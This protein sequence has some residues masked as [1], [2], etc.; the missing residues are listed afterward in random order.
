MQTLR[1]P[2]LIVGA[3]TGGLAAA[4]AC[5]RNGVRCIL[6]E[7]T[8]WV[9]GQLTTQAVPPDENPWIEGSGPN[10][11]AGFVGATAAYAQLRHEVREW[12]RTH[13]PLRPKV[14][15][16]PNLNPGAGWVSRLCAEPR[17]IE[18]VLRN[19]ITRSSFACNIDL[20]TGL[21][22]FRAEH[23]DDRIS[24][25]I[26]RDARTNE[27]IAIE[28]NLVL[29]A[30][31]LGDVLDLGS[32]ESLIGAE[33]QAV[34]GELHARTDLRQ[35]QSHDERDQQAFSW[36][37]AMEH[38]P[39]EDH[40]ID[41]PSGYDRWRTYVPEMAPPW[42]GPLMS[43]TVPSHDALKGRTLPMVPWPDE[44]EE[45]LLELW[46][47]R[48]IVNRAAYLETHAAEYP[49]VC[50]VNWVQ[51]D[52]WQHILLGVSDPQR[53]NAY[54]AAREQSR[55]LLYWMQTEAPRH[56]GGTGYP[57]L[58]LRGDELGTHDGFAKAAYIREPRRLLARTMLTEAHVGTEQRKRDGRPNQNATPWGAGEPFPDSIAIGHYPIDLH[59]TAAGRNNVYVP[60]CPFRIP[61]SSLVPVRVRNLIAAGKA[62]GVSHVANGCT[63]LHPVEWA[64]GEAAGLL[65]AWC[66]THGTEPFAV[67]EN[68]EAVA[69]LRSEAVGQGMPVSWPWES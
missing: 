52:H 1:T 54:E 42:T 11:P 39:E 59:P 62:L 19:T 31:D 44:P 55:C 45:G 60:A 13:R 63:R 29:D 57:G 5:A 69:R 15:A 18:Q 34:F 38:R 61:L 43:W 23:S 27:D 25:V 65:G 40:T 30:T 32:V 67:C 35:G 10:A 49:D 8:D 21:I 12:Y 17:V 50:L 28:A 33:S 58:R 4:I 68:S 53:A 22:L 16:M 2:V 66:L 56:D 51:M 47:Y 41:R 3:T 6:T 14:A 36:C 7:P 48:R 20:R 26:F 64:I 37:F 46:R 24:C 9:G